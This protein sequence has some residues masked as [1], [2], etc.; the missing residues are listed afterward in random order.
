MQD[1]KLAE[2][3]FDTVKELP[4]FRTTALEIGVNASTGVAHTLAN[5]L[6]KLVPE[7]VACDENDL[8]A[9]FRGGKDNYFF[10]YD[11][12]LGGLGVSKRA[13][14]SLDDVLR[15]ALRVAAKTCCEDGCFECTATGRSPSP[16]LENGDRRPTDKRGTYGLLAEILGEVVEETP[17]VT[18][19][20]LSLA[21]APAD[22][23]SQ[24]REML[25]LRGLS[26]TEVS[27][28]L[29]VPSRDLGRRLANSSPLRVT[30]E[31][32]GEGIVQGGSGSGERREVQV[33]FPG[34]GLKRLIVAHS[35]LEI[36]G[37]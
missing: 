5:L 15:R 36:S 30:H 6:R 32:F 24:A 2:H 25:E 20:S 13:F 37:T 12:W 8:G 18:T 34:H 27:A 7:R 10:L 9:A 26:L 28:K 35:K 19:P 1:H 3:P 31:K 17:A 23:F 29:G 14:E 21:G 11:D 4:P 16:F 22:W 33:Y